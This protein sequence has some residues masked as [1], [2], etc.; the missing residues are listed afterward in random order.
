M[1]PYISTRLKEQLRRK[2]ARERE[3][4]ANLITFSEAEQ[5]GAQNTPYTLNRAF[6][7]RRSLDTTLFE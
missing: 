5:T 4:L 7:E 2:I 6:F 3:K 1:T